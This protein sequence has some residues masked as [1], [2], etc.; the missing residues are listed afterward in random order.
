MSRRLPLADLVTAVAA[1]AVAV[2]QHYGAGTVRLYAL[3]GIW[4]TS[5]Q[6]AYGA[7]RIAMAAELAYRDQVTGRVTG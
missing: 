1:V 6:V 7:A 5:T 3:R 4:W 2:E